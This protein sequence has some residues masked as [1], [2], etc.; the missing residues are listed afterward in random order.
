MPNSDEIRDKCNSGEI[1]RMANGGV[2]RRLTFELMREMRQLIYRATGLL[3]DEIR[4]PQRQLETYEELF[5]EPERRAANAAEFKGHSWDTIPM[6][7]DE[8]MAAD[9]MQWRRGGVVVGVLADLW[10][11]RERAVRRG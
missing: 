8:T 9:C 11:E 5:P 10:F 6:L 2:P 3:P 4:S 1:C 7:L